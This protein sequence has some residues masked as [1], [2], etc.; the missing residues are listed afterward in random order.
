MS[1]GHLHSQSHH[2]DQ[3]LKDI[4]CNYVGTMVHRYSNLDIMTNYLSTY[5]VEYN[6]TLP[7][8]S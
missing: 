6:L 7:L 4:D 5:G 8:F 1:D 3:N 2:E